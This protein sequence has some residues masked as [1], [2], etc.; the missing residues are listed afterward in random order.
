MNRLKD[1]NVAKYGMIALRTD[2]ER[3]IITQKLEK[4]TLE[5]QKWD[6]YHL[7]LNK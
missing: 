2:A 6:I 7:N 1:C 3:V 4:K 5:T